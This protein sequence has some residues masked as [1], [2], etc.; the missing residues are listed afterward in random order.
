MIRK[1]KRALGIDFSLKAA[2]RNPSIYRRQLVMPRMSFRELVHQRLHDGR[3]ATVV[4]IGAN[5]GETN[6]PIGELLLRCADRITAALLVEPQQK[7]HARLARRYRDMAQVQCLKA[8]IDWTPGQR[9]LWSIDRARAE[10][11]IGRKV[12][13][14]IASFSRDHVLD[15]LCARSGDLERDEAERLLAPEDVQVKTMRQALTD[16]GIDGALNIVLIDTE[17][18]DGEV[19]RMLADLDLWPEIIQYEHKHLDRDERR[20]IARLLSGHGYRLWADHADVWG[21]RVSG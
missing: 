17:G 15:A 1:I 21:R 12:S 18:F 13:D 5:D 20:E 16:A 10:A 11:Q 2:M 14:G 19:I 4:Q 3:P 8:A 9:T 7:A 6:D